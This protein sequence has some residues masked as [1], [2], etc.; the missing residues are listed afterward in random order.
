M[1][2][3]GTLSAQ[4]YEATGSSFPSEWRVSRVLLKHCSIRRCAA[5]AAAGDSCKIN[6]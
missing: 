1:P 3:S 4:L 5:V 6:H 2:S